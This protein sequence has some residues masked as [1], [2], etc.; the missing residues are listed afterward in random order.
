[1]TPSYLFQEAAHQLPIQEGP[2]ES[3]L[4]GRGLHAL[5]RYP[6]R[7]EHY[8]ACKLCDAVCP[9]QAITIEAE[10]TADGSYCITHYDTDMP[11]R[12]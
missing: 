11:K 5:C 12:I 2:A 6:T 7:E 1:M 3:T 4:W 9:A 10:P 8:T